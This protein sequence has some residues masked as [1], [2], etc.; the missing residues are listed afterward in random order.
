MLNYLHYLVPI[1]IILLPLL[2]NKVLF[3][4]YSLK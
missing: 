4:L 3:K 2:P 1:S